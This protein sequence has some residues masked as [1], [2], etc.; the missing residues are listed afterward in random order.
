MH[1]TL[2]KEYSIQEQIFDYKKHMSTWFNRRYCSSDDIRSFTFESE[3]WLLKKAYHN[4]DR[5]RVDFSFLSKVIYNK[6][7][8]TLLKCFLAYMLMDGYSEATVTEYYSVIKQFYISSHGLTLVNELSDDEIKNYCSQNERIQLYI[9]IKF[10]DFVIENSFYDTNYN[11]LV[12]AK[13]K[14]N[15]IH[16][17][18]NKTDESREIPC[19]KDISMFQYYL[20]KFET[21]EQDEDIRNLFFPVIIW[22]RTSIMIPIRPSEI[23]YTLE[24]DCIFKLNGACY[25]RINRIKGNL[26][27]RMQ[28]PIAKKLCISKELYDLIDRYQKLVAYDTNAVTLFSIDFLRKCFLNVREKEDIFRDKAN[29][30][31]RFYEDYTHFEGV[32]LNQLID[33]FYDFYIDRQVDAPKEYDRLRAGDTRHLAFSSLLLQNLNPIDIA[34]IGGHTSLNSLSSYVNHIDLY[35]DSEIYRYYNKIDLNTDNYSKKLKEII[36]N[37]PFQAPSNIVDCIPDEYG[38]GYCTDRSFSCED[39]LCFF[40]S[41]WWCRPQNENFVKTAHFISRRSVV[42]L[43]NELNANKKMLHALLNKASVELVN[44]N[45]ILKEEY[46]SEYRQL[47]KAITGNATRLEM[48][49]E[50]LLLNFN[51][52]EKKNE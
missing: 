19:N 24:K 45:M 27:K 5:E 26:I 40:C 47:I 48:L 29:T 51:V 33:L 17:V 14:L 9:P 4:N 12:K 7:D 28:I 25:I 22:W 6:N 3:V 30:F 1:N 2:Q 38:I 34:M 10:I 52:E 41:K 39:D 20:H 50:S 8:K 42:Q 11:T 46:Y 16:Q 15:T 31:L 18:D 36:M 49:K 37:M 32:D 44:G 13:N 43:K 35:I 21:T 23:T